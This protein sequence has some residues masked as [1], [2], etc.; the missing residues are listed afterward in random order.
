MN[1]SK[2]TWA[3]EFFSYYADNEP[4]LQKK[5][6]HAIDNGDIEH[7]FSLLLFGLFVDPI[8]NAK[9]IVNRWLKKVGFERLSIRNRIDAM[10]LYLYEQAKNIPAGDRLDVFNSHMKEYVEWSN[11]RKI[12]FIEINT[13]GDLYTVLS[14]NSLVSDTKTMQSKSSTG[15]EIDDILFRYVEENR[16][17]KE[18]LQCI[19]NEPSIRAYNKRATYYAQKILYDIIKFPIDLMCGHNLPND[20]ADRKNFE[21]T[22]E[23]SFKDDEKFNRFAN[24]NRLFLDNVKSTEFRNWIYDKENRDV[25]NCIKYLEDNNISYERLFTNIYGFFMLCSYNDAISH[26]KNS[27]DTNSILNISSEQYEDIYGK[28]IDCRTKMRSTLKGMIS[29]S[30]FVSRTFLVM[31]AFY[32]GY[33]KEKINNILSKSDYDVLNPRNGFDKVIL[34]FLSDDFVAQ[35]RRIINGKKFIDRIRETHN[36]DAKDFDEAYKG[37]KERDDYYKTQ[38]SFRERFNEVLRDSDSEF[39]CEIFKKT[40][41]KKIIAENEKELQQINSKRG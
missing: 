32:A 25:S 39:L 26:L 27:K 7:R 3:D 2:S 20:E 36:Q 12:E 28:G 16:P 34:E 10:F 33:N 6:D 22:I 17:L 11:G 41:A 21:E 18:F 30:I 37:Q 8:D 9:L 5:I 13:F 19:E 15:R 35:M 24:Y 1:Y 31:F 29:G 40:K 14:H 38:D 4:E 23:M